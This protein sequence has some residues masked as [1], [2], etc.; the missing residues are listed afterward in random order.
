MLRNQWR[1][2]ADHFNRY[3]HILHVSGSPVIFRC[4]PAN[5]ATCLF[6]QDFFRTD[7]YLQWQELQTIVTLPQVPKVQSTTHFGAALELLGCL[8]GLPSCCTAPVTGPQ[9]GLDGFATLVIITCHFAH[10]GMQTWAWTV[11]PGLY[12]LD[13]GRT[14][15]AGKVE[16][17]VNS[18]PYRN[19]DRPEVRPPRHA[20]SRAYMPVTL[21][22]DP[23]CFLYQPPW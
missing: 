3:Q 10:R 1:T 7:R 11:A 16:G 19:I 23:A 18:A 22:S 20:A 9:A 4:R 8:V 6:E 13:V 15:S 17:T 2:Q 5:A 21:G 14:F 12:Q